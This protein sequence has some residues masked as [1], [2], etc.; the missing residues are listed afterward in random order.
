MPAW[1]RRSVLRQRSWSYGDST[2]DEGQRL[3]SVQGEVVEAIKGEFDGT[4]QFTVAQAVPPLTPPASGEFI[5]GLE[6][7]GHGALYFSNETVRWI[8][9]TPNFLAAAR[10]AR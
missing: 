7:G 10:E 1:S 9:A 2:E 4:V 8:P 6:R 3:F 5:V